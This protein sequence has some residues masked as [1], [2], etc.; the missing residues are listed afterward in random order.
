MCLWLDLFVKK[1]SVLELTEHWSWE[2]EALDPEICPTSLLGGSNEETHAE[3]LTLFL[4]M[5]LSRGQNVL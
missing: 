4:A 1:G 5:V 3:G 2:S